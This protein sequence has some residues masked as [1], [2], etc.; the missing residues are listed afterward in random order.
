MIVAV[1]R[2]IRDV[3]PIVQGGLIVPALVTFSVMITESFKV[4]VGSATWQSCQLVATG[5]TIYI[6][7]L[8]LIWGYLR[9][10]A[11]RN[12]AARNKA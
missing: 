8:C 12:R 2:L 4:E 11:A 7:A 6:L 10:T 9:P 5:A 3:K 1:I